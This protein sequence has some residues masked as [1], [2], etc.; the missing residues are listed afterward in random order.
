[1]SR[2]A[3][4]GLL[5]TSGTL[6]FVLMLFLLAR[7]TFLFADVYTISAEFQSVAGLEA[8]APVQYRGIAVGSVE[9]VV[10]PESPDKPIRVEMA[11][12]R[13]AGRLVR[14]D[15]KAQI[16]ADGVLGNQLVVLVGGSDQAPPVEE[17]GRIAGVE[18][19]EIMALAEQAMS[20]VAVFDSVILSLNDVLRKIEEGEGSV[21]R[22]LED[23]D[24]YERSVRLA[25]RA[26]GAL[27][28]LEHT[29]DSLTRRIDRTLAGVDS[30]VTDVQRG[31]GALARLIND[32]E[33]Y[34]RVLE[35]GHR[36]DELL[37]ETDSLV[38]EARSASEWGTVAL[39][40]AAETM[41]GLQQHW[42]FRRYFRDNPDP[43][44]A[45]TD[46][47]LQEQ[48]ERRSASE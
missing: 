34:D 12:E 36:L 23:P 21:A 48:Q 44:R 42:L 5:I 35:T 9:K 46:S 13:E 47:L 24:L 43:Y 2:Q 37:V 30:L 31:D 32:P 39:F 3:R 26:E 29:M 28:G 10:L 4:L 33:L 16:K 18:P 25:T 14:A 8:G 17:G 7:R 15:S 45:T 22:L 40:R 20:T 41:A 6:L 11:I 27:K 1:M 19:M 38:T